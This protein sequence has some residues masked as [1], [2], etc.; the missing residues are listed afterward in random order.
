MDRTTTTAATA[1]RRVFAMMDLDGDGVISA[2][3]YLSRIDRVVG[4]TGRTEDDALVITARAEGAKAWR[5]M[6]ANADGRLT[7]EE[8]DAWVDGEKFDNICRFALGSLF[9]L[10]DADGD[11]ALNRDEF[12]TLRTALNNPPGNAKAAFDALDADG[13]GLVAR[14][15][16]LAAIRAYVVG[17]NSPMGEAL[18]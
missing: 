11:G 6:D 13:D 10:V 14:G 12:T 17:D 3:D 2:Q 15:A 1:T 5:A 7:F 18:Y 9:D 16:Y 8:Y 4:A